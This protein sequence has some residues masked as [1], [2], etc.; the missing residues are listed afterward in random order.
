[1]FTQGTGLIRRAAPFIGD[2][3]QRELDLLA[4]PGRRTGIE[5]L[6]T[7]RGGDPSPTG[8]GKRILVLSSPIGS[9]RV[10]RYPLALIFNDL[11]YREGREP[12]Q[13]LAALGD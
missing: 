13:V 1:M 11:R 5:V 8:D 4:C 6:S 2:E 3:Q 10:N 9:Q 7:Q 12:M